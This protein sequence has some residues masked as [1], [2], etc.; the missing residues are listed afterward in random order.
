MAAMGRIGLHPRAPLAVALALA[1]VLIGLACVVAQAAV[2]AE[3]PQP[4]EWSGAIPIDPGT[5]IDAVSCTS[6][7]LCVAIDATGRV[8]STTEP[9][10]AP[11]SWTSA[12]VPGAEPAGTAMSCLASGPLCVG[13]AGPPGTLITSSEPTGGEHAWSL[14]SVDAGRTLTGV[15]CSEPTLCVAVDDHGHAL[16]STDPAAGPG[17]WTSV[18]IDG[19]VRLGSVSCPSVSLCVAVDGADNVVT[20]TE[21]ANPAHPWTVT[22]IPV[23]GLHVSCTPGRL[24]VIAGLN[25]ILTS[26]D[27]TGP[28]SAWTATEGVD[29]SGGVSCPTAAR[30]VGFAGDTNGELIVTSEPGGGA[31]AWERD[32]AGFRDMSGV[33]CVSASECVAVDP[34]GNVFV[35]T[36]TYEL[37]LA[38]GGTAE[39]TVDSTPIAC[40]FATCGHEVPGLIEPLP[41]VEIA[42]ADTFG[43]A[44]GPWG[45]CALGFPEGNRVTLAATPAPGAAF[46]GW[47]GACAGAGTA[48]CTIEMTANREVTAA[49]VPAAPGPPSIG[50]RETPPR[51]H[52]RRGATVPHISSLHESNSVFAVAGHAT[53]LDGR[54]ASRHPRGTV[55]SFVL[56]QPATVTVTVLTSAKGRRLGGRC[57]APSRRLRHRPSCRRRVTVA[58]LTRKGHRGLNRIVFTGRIGFLALHPAG[59]RALFAAFDATGPAVP[60]SLPFTIVPR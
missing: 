16:V 8:L 43:L 4:L 33:S 32:G 35:S 60:Q 2:A 29:V 23:A 36:G 38:L 31:G 15:S 14:A 20:S 52:P 28:T 57:L 47:G 59:Y 45:T 12:S 6:T 53:P 22:P 25:T 41:I 17:A 39:G 54:T 40:P 19:E 3:P 9:A 48:P 27:P 34:F 24:C 30:C 58:V 11:G 18:G 13:I 56:D 5:K 49:F 7:A 37:G 21:P 51:I 55:F 26:T 46:A 10:G 50:P 44:R 1:A 42:C